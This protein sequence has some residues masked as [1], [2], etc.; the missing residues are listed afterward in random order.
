MLSE[1]LD[2]VQPTVLTNVLPFPA[3][4]AI[5]LLLQSVLFTNVPVKSCEMPLLPDPTILA[6]ALKIC[7]LFKV[8]VKG[9]PAGCKILAAGVL[10]LNNVAEEESMISAVGVISI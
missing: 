5:F 2:W 7:P 8:I 9:T 6:M 1:P 4:T 10:E 3:H